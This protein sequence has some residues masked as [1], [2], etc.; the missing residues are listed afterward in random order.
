MQTQQYMQFESEGNLWIVNSSTI[1]ARKVFMFSNQ[2]IQLSDDMNITSPDPKFM[3]DT[4]VRINATDAFQSRDFSIRRMWRTDIYSNNSVI[5][6]RGLYKVHSLDMKA[7]AYLK[8]SN[9][10]VMYAG[11]IFMSSNNLTLKNS[12]YHVDILQSRGAHTSI[13]LLAYNYLQVVEQSDIISS[14]IFLKSDLGLS[15]ASSNIES[16]E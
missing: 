7:R 4:F 11:S 5:V 16:L 2:M 10:T 6:G 3:N 12:T 1:L 13:R 14:S 15:I 9:L 8:S